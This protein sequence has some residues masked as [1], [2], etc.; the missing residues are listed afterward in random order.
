MIKEERG[1][2]NR[3]WKTLTIID[4]AKGSINNYE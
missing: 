4:E 3:K 2:K 1:V